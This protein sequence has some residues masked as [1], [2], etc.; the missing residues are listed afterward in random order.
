MSERRLV[1]AGEVARM[2][3]AQAER[4][5]LDLLPD[6]RRQGHEWVARN[7]TR[8]DGRP[9]SF[10]IHIGGAKSGV[11]KDF[12]S[13]QKG[14]MLD[15]VAMVMFAGDKRQAFQWGLRFLGLASGDPAALQRA[16]QAVP[17]AA[18]RKAQADKEDQDAREA[19]RRIWFGAE[20]LLRDTPVDRYLA[21]RGIN[22]AELR[23]Q[24]GA[25]RFH[26]NLWHTGSERKWPAMVT[27]VNRPDVPGGFAAVHRTWLEVG[28]DGRV[29]KAPVE[30]NKKVLGSFKG[31]HM[32][33]WRGATNRRLPDIRD[34]EVLHIT[35]GIE[36][37][38]SVVM[39]APEARVIAAISLSNMGGVILPTE[40]RT[41]MLWR[42]NDKAPE[43]ISQFQRAMEAHQRAGRVVLLPAIPA[44]VKDVNDLLTSGDRVEVA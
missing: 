18:E 19:A 23:R 42:Q 9:G 36:D 29:R 22:L 26:P 16:R 14:D 20:P 43:A 3:D 30:G 41:V 35:E 17:S 4:I 44:E 11:W 38:L 24:P 33:I 10:C 31:G 21:G 40:C 34:D 32:A 27:A 6:G 12:A 8:A 13:G 15:L 37:G 1:E 25:I 2:L 39:G 5:C 28:S 7:P